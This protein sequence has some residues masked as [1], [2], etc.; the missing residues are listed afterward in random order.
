MA[1]CGVAGALISVLQRFRTIATSKYASMRSMKIDGAIRMILGG[2]FGALFLLLQ[3]GE[4]LLGGLT[5]NPEATAS[6]ALVAGFSERLIPGI[7]EKL[8]Q[9]VEVRTQE[10]KKA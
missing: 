3:N 9:K 5:S 4:L 8:G 2:S 10:V 6:F 7:L 1:A